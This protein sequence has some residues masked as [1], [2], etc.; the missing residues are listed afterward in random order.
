MTHPTSPATTRPRSRW[1]F[2][3]AGLMVFMLGLASGL[4]V[5]R[6]EHVRWFDG[7]LAAFAVWYLVGSWSQAAAIV[8]AGRMVVVP[9]LA[10][11]AIWWPVAINIAAPLLVALGAGLLL[12]RQHRALH[13]HTLDD[14]SYSQAFNY[15]C[16]GLIFVP[17]LMTTQSPQRT[18]SNRQGVTGRLVAA[19]ALVGGLGVAVLAVV[20][21][22]W[23]VA[24]IH[25]AIHGIR[26][27]QRYRPEGDPFG[28][29]AFFPADYGEFCT[30]AAVA[31]LVWLAAGGLLCLFAQS[32]ARTRRSRISIVLFGIT[33]A[34]LVGLL[35]TGSGMLASHISPTMSRF[36]VGDKPVILWSLGFLFLTV[37][38]TWMTQRLAR[39]EPNEN[40]RVSLPN[41]PQLFLHQWLIVLALPIVWWWASQYSTFSAINEMFQLSGWALLEFRASLLIEDTTALFWLAS[42]IALLGTAWRRWRGYDGEVLELPQASP[43][44]LAAVWLGCV[45][46]LATAGPVWAWL[47]FALLMRST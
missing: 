6:L 47:G 46:L 34:A 21:Q 38:A 5:T 28:E 18:A 36:V 20:N 14:V 43:G 45:A 19:A 24:L 40:L 29:R 3:L 26:Q 11:R 42:T 44:Q 12:A 8:R 7:L 2:T 37:A 33:Q 10:R 15:L 13:F 30:L 22:V 39:G 16:V 27:Y 23:I 35:A 31:W 17:P 4:A 1:R 41:G 25:F 9:E 32:G